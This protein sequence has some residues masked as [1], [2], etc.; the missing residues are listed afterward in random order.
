MFFTQKCEEFCDKSV[1][2]QSKMLK[3]FEKY[4]W[5]ELK[6]YNIQYTVVHE[7]GFTTQYHTKVGN[8]N[9]PFDPEIETFIS[10]RFLGWIQAGKSSIFQNVLHDDFDK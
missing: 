2:T 10:F 4:F 1:Y 6:G 7:L 9:K 3:G 5:K 8:L